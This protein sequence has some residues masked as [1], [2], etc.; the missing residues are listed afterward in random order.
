MLT[1]MSKIV[2]IEAN[3]TSI[4]KM[5]KSSEPDDFSMDSYSYNNSISNSEAL[6]D[7]E[8]TI[9]V[10][11]MGGGQVKEPSTSWDMA[12]VYAAAA[13]FPQNVAKTPQRTWSVHF[14]HPKHHITNIIVGLY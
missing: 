7:T 13:A 5:A 6:K 11:W 2:H 1:S 14:W 9:T 8:T 4:K 3:W 10:S 12:S